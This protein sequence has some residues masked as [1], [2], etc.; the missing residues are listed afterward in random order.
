MLKTRWTDSV[1]L[2]Q[3]LNDYPRPQFVRDSYFSL[4]GKWQYKITKS[5]AIT[6]DYDGEIVV[7]FSPESELSGVNRT[8]GPNDYLI[9][10]K[11]FVLPSDFNKG[12]V[13]INFGAVDQ[14]ATVYINGKCVGTHKGGYTPFRFELSEY[15][16]ESE[17]DLVVLVKDFSD[18]KSYSRGKQKINRGGIWYTAQSGIWQSVWLESTPIE[19]LDSVRITPD[20]DNELVRFEFFGTDD[21][22]TL[23]YDGDELIADTTEH[24]VKIPDFKPWSPE[25]PFLYKVVFK[26]CGEKIKSYFGMRKFSVGTDGMGIK[27]LLLNNK[28]YFH[29][30]LLDQ[31]YYPDTMLTPPCNEAMENDIKFVKNAGFNMLRKHIKIEPLLWYHYCDVNGIIVWQDMVNGGGSYGLEVSAIPFV[32][33]TLDDTKYKTFARE[34]KEGRDLYYQELD[35]MISHLYNCPCIAVWVPFN[36]GWG[37]FDSRIAYE[38]IKALDSTRIVDTTSGWHDLGHSDVIS[39]HIYFTPIKVK[40]GDRPYVLS[41]F[42]GF[43]M[44]IKGHTFNEKMFGYKIYNSKNSLTKAYERLFNN[45]IIPQIKDGLSATVYTQLT[46]V[47]DELNGL[48]TYDRELQKI[49]V[50]KLKE[51][52]ERIKL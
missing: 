11:T 24:T 16:N 1:D 49:D 15:I 48:L 9:Y 19:H 40:A 34:D 33:I 2:S 7:P 41:E 39:K 47:E 42:G 13:Y 46:D 5:P 32:N 18:T 38:K 22:E 17:N 3:P 23:I 20:Y 30:G 10:K 43:S 37:Q 51:I 8:V 31:G 50:D 25:N 14:I 36:E 26:A 29:N 44:R 4:N 35:E 52:N 27:R 6:D 45:V 12:R 21:V 28:P